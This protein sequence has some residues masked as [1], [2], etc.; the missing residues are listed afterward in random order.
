MRCLHG[1]VAT[2]VEDL[3]VVAD[4]GLSGGVV[5]HPLLSGVRRLGVARAI[6]HPSLGSESVRIW[7]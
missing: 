1:V 2:H 5:T 4:V 3:V 7:T 6:E